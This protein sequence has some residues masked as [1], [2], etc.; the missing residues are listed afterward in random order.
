M[1]VSSFASALLC[2]HHAI[3]HHCGASPDTVTIPLD[4]PNI[5]SCEENKLLYKLPGLWHSIE[6]TENG[7][8]HIN[9]TRIELISVL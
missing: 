6:E 5:Q 7:L 2:S 9:S 1:K 4:V 3:T 8:R